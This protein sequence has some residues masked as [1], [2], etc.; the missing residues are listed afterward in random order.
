MSPAQN[1]D[2]CRSRVTSKFHNFDVTVQTEVAL[3]R[4]RPVT[5]LGPHIMRI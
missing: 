5:D 3:Q 1:D 2:Q 4:I